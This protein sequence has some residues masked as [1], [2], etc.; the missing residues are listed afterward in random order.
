M[1]IDGYFHSL[2]RMMKKVLDMIIGKSSF[3]LGKDLIY[4]IQAQQVGSSF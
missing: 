3:P 2:K 4:M 1:Q